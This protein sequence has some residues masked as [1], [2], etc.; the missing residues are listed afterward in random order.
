MFCGPCETVLKQYGCLFFAIIP[1]SGFAR[2]GLQHMLLCFKGMEGDQ[3]GAFTAFFCYVHDTCQGN[4]V[5][6]FRSGDRFTE[7]IARLYI[8]EVTT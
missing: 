2:L 5:K 8:V 3:F 7:S 4:F 6:K 1:F